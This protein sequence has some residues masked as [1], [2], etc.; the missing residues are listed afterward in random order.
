MTEPAAILDLTLKG[1]KHSHHVWI[2]LTETISFF[3][4]EQVTHCAAGKTN[5]LD[6][7]HYC[8]PGPGDY[9]AL[10]LYNLLLNNPRY[11][12]PS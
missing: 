1:R 9:W 8:Y 12:D 4:N 11:R 5:S 10:S 2:Q 3:T 7:L 6:C